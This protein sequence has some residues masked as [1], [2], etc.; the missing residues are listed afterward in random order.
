MCGYDKRVRY[1][2][3]QTGELRHSADSETPAGLGRMWTGRETKMILCDSRAGV[4]N[5][6]GRFPRSFRLV[7][8]HPIDEVLQLA[9]LESGIE[10]RINLELR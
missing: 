5:V 3:N 4:G 7:V 1:A 6:V 10:D 2:R 8:A 9:A